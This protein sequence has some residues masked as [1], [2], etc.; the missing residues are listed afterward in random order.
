MDEVQ[1]VH[2]VD[3]VQ[4]AHQLMSAVPTPSS[5]RLYTLSLPSLAVF[6]QM[7]SGGRHCT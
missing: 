6:Q 4:G 7:C 5:D 1:R 2:G 3:E